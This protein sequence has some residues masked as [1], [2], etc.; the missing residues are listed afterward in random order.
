MLLSRGLVGPFGL[1]VLPGQAGTTPVGRGGLPNNGELSPFWPKPDGYVRGDIWTI[2]RDYKNQL[3]AQV[4]NTK[5]I[6][7]QWFQSGMLPQCWGQAD[8]PYGASLALQAKNPLACTYSKPSAH[9]NPPEVQPGCEGS[10]I[11]NYDMHSDGRAEDQATPPCSRWNSIDWRFF[12]RGVRVFDQQLIE[13]IGI[14]RILGVP[15]TLDQ[16]NPDKGSN[17]LINNYSYTPTEDQRFLADRAI[18]MKSQILMSKNF[19]RN[20][21][22]GDDGGA[23]VPTGVSPSFALEYY[24]ANGELDPD[25]SIVG[26][27]ASGGFGPQGMYHGKALSINSFITIMAGT[28]FPGWTSKIAGYT[29]NPLSPT[30]DELNGPGGLLAY[31]ARGGF[32]L[33]EPCARGQVS[34]EPTPTLRVNTGFCWCD[35]AWFKRGWWNEPGFSDP[36]RQSTE[37]KIWNMAPS[38]GTPIPVAEFVPGG[39]TNQQFVYIN[40]GTGDKYTMS[41]KA[42]SSSA[43]TKTANFLHDLAMWFSKVLCSIAPAAQSFNKSLLTESCVDI[44]TGNPCKKGTQGCVCKPPTSGDKEAVA[45]ANMGIQLFC[46]E[47]MPQTLPPVAPPLMPTPGS[48]DFTPYLLIGAAVIGGYLLSRKQ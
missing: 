9:S 43:L 32:L 24:V 31:Y 45:A 37:Y 46:K 27:I 4:Q 14:V 35:K 42:M 28:G 6:L 2:T 30:N 33:Y 8:S 12:Q 18:Y 47:V 23:N 26:V 13:P 22:P 11:V 20:V 19:G 39:E 16:F 17:T 48:K 36:S 34:V 40:I 15:F 7:T 10:S 38:Q 5:D 41:V 25:R 29:F 3:R 44:A 21:S 1:G